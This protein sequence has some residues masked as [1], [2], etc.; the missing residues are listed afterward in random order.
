MS[1]RMGG[2]LKA[3]GGVD[4][5]AVITAISQTSSTIDFAT[6]NLSV[7]I[8]LTTLDDEG[9]VYTSTDS[10]VT[11]PSVSEGD[12]LIIYDGGGNSADYAKVEVTM[13]YS[14]Y[15]WV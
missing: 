7:Y 15:S 4:N 12:L 5:S 2:I 9:S 13:V 14:S 3:D 1:I 10:G 11:F 8:D 6:S